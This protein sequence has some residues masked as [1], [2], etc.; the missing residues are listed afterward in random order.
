MPQIAQLLEIYASQMFWLLVTFGIIYFGIARMMLPKVEATMVSREKKI[1]DDLAA[2]EQA[3]AAAET[4]DDEGEQILSDARSEAQAKAS[5]AK[6]KA[7]EDAEKR[8]GKA[9]AEISEKLAAA[10]AEVAKARSKAM[11]EIEGVAKEAAADIASKVAGVEVTAV[12]AGKAVGR[13]MAN[14]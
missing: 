7:A 12:Q 9:D 6:A 14:G 13:V 10:E 1:A 8:I 11:L 4:A 3:H 2:A 5:A